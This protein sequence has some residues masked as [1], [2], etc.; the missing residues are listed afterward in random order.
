MRRGASGGAMPRDT[1][2]LIVGSGASELLRANAQYLKRLGPVPTPFG[3]SAPL[4]RARMQDAHFL[5][6][7]TFM[8][9]QHAWL[10]IGGRGQ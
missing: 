4:Y 10:L 1:F 7:R 2:A 8:H 5:A 3:L 9:D 6:P